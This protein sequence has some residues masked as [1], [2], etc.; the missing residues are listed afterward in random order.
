MYSKYTNTM[1]KKTTKKDFITTRLWKR[2]LQNL[3]FVKAYA[4]ETSV[5]I[6]DRLVK[7]ELKKVSSDKSFSI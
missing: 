4:G 2:T 5:Q 6:L 1:K 3:R 7:E